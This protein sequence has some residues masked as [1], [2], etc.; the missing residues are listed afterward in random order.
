MITGNNEIKSQSALA[1]TMFEH[2]F[3][4]QFI[5]EAF[6]MYVLNPRMVYTVSE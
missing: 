3:H 4:H 6:Q 2:S 1:V 5:H